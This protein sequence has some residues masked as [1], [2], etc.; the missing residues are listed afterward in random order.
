[1]NTY[2]KKG[3]LHQHFRIFHLKDT[4]M[5]EIPFH[6]HD[7]HKI[8]IFIDGEGQYIIEGKNYPLKPRDILFV[9]A[10]EIHRPVT[11]PGKLYERIVIYVSQ[12]FLTHWQNEQWNEGEVDLSSCFLRAKESS[13]V[14]H[15]PK[16]TEHDLLFHMKKIE[17]VDKGQGFA[18]EL[19]TEILFIEFMILLNR[20]LMTNQLE[21][22]H[23]ATYDPKVQLVL[24]YINSHLE[25]DLTVDLLAD[26]VFVS[27]Y[28]LMR[29]F[30]A[31]TGYSVHQYISS[32]RLLLAKELLSTTSAPITDI[33]FQCGFKDYSTFSR[34]FKKQ[35]KISARKYRKS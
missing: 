14:M 21:K 26:T 34:E 27:K 7:F 16:G 32:K 23:E 35:F 10:G 33:C 29:K 2:K 3:F 1:M 30:K 28:H 5:K 9:S 17:K 19:Y 6:Y 18:N 8:I 15:M 11:Y 13:S 31:E 4:A 25:E 20:A 22:L 12:D 24:E